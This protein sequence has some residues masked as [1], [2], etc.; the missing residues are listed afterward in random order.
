MAGIWAIAPDDSGFGTVQGTTGI[1]LNRC[2]ATTERTALGGG[3]MRFATD[4]QLGPWTLS[5][6]EV[7]YVV[8]GTLSLATAAETVELGPGEIGLLESGTT[9]TY[10]G[11]AG[12]TA[13]YALTP[14]DWEAKS[15]PL[16]MSYDH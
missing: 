15:E 6:D 10:H 8:A 5:Y 11:T 2:V 12:T 16:G 13:F 4:D 9:V 7:F 1:E 3:V 14:R